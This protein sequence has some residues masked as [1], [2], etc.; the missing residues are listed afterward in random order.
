MSETT[1]ATTEQTAATETAAT[2][3]QQAAAE[4][5]TLDLTNLPADHPL[6]KALAA[7]KEEL[8]E[9]RP[10]K[11]KAKQWDEFE[12][13]NKTELQKVQDRAAAAEA[14]AAEAETRA[15]RADI[16]SKTGVPSELIHGATAEDM[17]ASAQA[18]LAFKGSTT[19]AARSGGADINGGQGQPKTYSQARMQS[20]HAY[21][22][23]N[24]DAILA[25]QAE[26][27]APRITP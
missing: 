5:S 3:A 12:E 23:E 18:A 1:E 11:S 26:P 16:A 7:Q 2:E 13:A 24:R 21:Y 25:A 27:G 6:V 15:L 14:R 4:T 17:E 10:L 22:V 8:R 9:L 20:D 19:T